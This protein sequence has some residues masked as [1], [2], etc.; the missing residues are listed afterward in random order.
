MGQKLQDGKKVLEMSVT[1]LHSK[2]RPIQTIHPTDLGLL[3][4]WISI[5]RFLIILPLNFRPLKLVPGRWKFLCGWANNRIPAGQKTQVCRMDGLDRASLWVRVKLGHFKHFF[6][7]LQLLTHMLL[8]LYT[9]YE[10]ISLPNKILNSAKTPS[11]QCVRL[12][13]KTRSRNGFVFENMTC[14]INQQTEYPVNIHNN[15]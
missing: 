10:Y 13:I 14:K 15:W 5:S 3:P 7:V 4:S 12:G 2:C 11:G 9:F 8:A 1:T 6:P